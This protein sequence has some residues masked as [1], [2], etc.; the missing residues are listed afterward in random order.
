MVFCGGGNHR[1]EKFP[2][3]REAGN[4]VIL[5]PGNIL[6][7]INQGFVSLGDSYL[8]S[9]GRRESEVSFCSGNTFLYHL[10]PRLCSVSTFLFIKEAVCR[11]I[12]SPKGQ[13]P[14]K[15]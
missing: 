9:P 5:A 15:T 13:N 1:S 12:S 3:G 14:A 8:L 11:V 6:A 2:L 10:F 7:C 4:H